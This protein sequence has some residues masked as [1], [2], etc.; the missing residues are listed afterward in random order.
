MKRKP[1]Q[2]AF[3]GEGGSLHVLCDDGTIWY[4]GRSGWVQIN[5]IPQPEETEDEQVSY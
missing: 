4:E 2:I 1:I 3:E 5:D